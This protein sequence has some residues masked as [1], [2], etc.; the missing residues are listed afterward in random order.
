[1]LAGEGLRLAD[2]RQ[3]LALQRVGLGRPPYAGVP[4]IVSHPKPTH[5]RELGAKAFLRQVQGN[6]PTYQCIRRQHA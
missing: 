5:L 4:E 6:L 1:M 2:A 3:F